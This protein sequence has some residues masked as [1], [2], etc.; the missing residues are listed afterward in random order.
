MEPQSQRLIGALAGR[1]L[2]TET[3][4]Q[5][6]GEIRG[7]AASHRNAAVHSGVPRARQEC[8]QARL[9]PVQTR[10]DGRVHPMRQP[11][12]ARTEV[13]LSGDDHLRGR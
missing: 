11:I 5:L 1:N 8:A 10:R 3:P 6:V 13:I 4:S 2:G 9:V 12:D 7:V